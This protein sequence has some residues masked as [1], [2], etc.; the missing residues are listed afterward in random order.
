MMQYP[1]Q[2][3][4]QLK[5]S[6]ARCTLN[7]VMGFRTFSQQCACTLIEVNFLSKGIVCLFIQTLIVISSARLIANRKWVFLS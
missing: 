7:L 5:L 2:I 6:Q 1:R 3:Q 4:G